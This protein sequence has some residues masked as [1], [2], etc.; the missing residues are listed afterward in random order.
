MNATRLR[1]RA[2]DLGGRPRTS[3]Y[4]TPAGPMLQGVNAKAPQNAA[5]STQ[6]IPA[7]SPVGL[8]NAEARN[9]AGITG[10]RGVRYA[11]VRPRV[12][13]GPLPKLSTGTGLTARKP[14]TALGYTPGGYTPPKQV[15]TAGYEYMPFYQA[16]VRGAFESVSATNPS[17]IPARGVSA[18]NGNTLAP[19][20]NAHDWSWWVNRFQTQGRSPGAW[21]ETGFPPGYRSL[22]RR[23]P[24]IGY[25]LANGVALARPLSA[26][27]YN[28]PWR[29]PANAAARIG[30]GTGMPLGYNS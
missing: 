29:T 2:V 4:N 8:A 14:A 10:V 6:R 21:Q 28:L 23:R 3:F 9:A 17:G 12:A 18:E 30:G 5:R 11:G 25:N 24:P 19:T 26:A 1:P 13:L 20:Y 22:I 15:F 16:D 7:V 27:A